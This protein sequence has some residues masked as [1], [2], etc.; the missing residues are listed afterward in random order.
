MDFNDSPQEAEFRKEAHDWLSKNAKPRSD[1][2]NMMSMFAESEGG[3]SRGEAEWE[4]VRQ[5]QEWQKLKAD[6]GWAGITWPKKF[7]GRG[8]NIMQQ[9][10][11]GQEEAKFETPPNIFMIGI[12]M[13][14]PTIQ[15]HGTNEQKER[16]LKPMLRGEEVW[17]QLF[18]EP[19]AGSDLAGLRTKAVK[20]G[21]DWVV[22][23]QK[24]W[25]SGAHYSQWGILVTR[26][27]PTAHKHKGL[28]YFIVDMKSPGIEIRPIKQI[29]GGANFNEVF[30]ND[31]RIPDENRLGAPGQGWSVAITTLMNERMSIGGG[32]GGLGGDMGLSE[33][34]GALKTTYIDD[35]PA[36]EHEAV[37]QKLAEFMARFKGLELTGYRTLS[38]LSQGAMPGPEGSIMKLAMGLLAQEMAALIMELQGAANVL[39]DKDETLMGAM[40]QQV[41]LGIPAIRIA[42][43]TDEIQRN[44][45]GERVLGLPPDVRLDKGVPFNEVP[46]GPKAKA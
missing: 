6:A 36:I 7:G 32:G 20:D 9:V 4:M 30:F 11:W 12:G 29:T 42:G 27:D 10:I 22:N 15:A 21:N 35:K 16:Y 8:G 13:A 26:S 37:R 43:G 25:T 34:L 39:T 3:D 1:S 5:A 23:G 28:T 24:V 38:A 45:I 41:Y 2:G 40:W 17:C 19:G 14:G 33:V 46:T 31:V 18:S 44:I